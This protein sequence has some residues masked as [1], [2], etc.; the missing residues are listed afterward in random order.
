MLATAAKARS[1]CACGG[2]AD[3]GINV[4]KGKATQAARNGQFR[5]RDII[6]GQ[7]VIRVPLFGV[8][9]VMSEALAASTKSARND[10]S[11]HH[12][13]T[14]VE[15]WMEMIREINREQH[16]DELEFHA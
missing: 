3:A 13:L 16:Q 11:D 15:K 10:T 2:R 4:N 12:V 5:L 7:R 6:R 9:R 1:M 14:Q 8:V